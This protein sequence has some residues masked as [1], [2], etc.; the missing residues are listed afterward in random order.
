[1]RTRRALPPAEPRQHCI[2][3]HI[4]FSRP[5]SRVFGESV[6]AVRRRLGRRLAQ[7][8]PAEADVVIAVPDSSNSIALG[9]SEASGMPLRAGAHPQPLRRPHVH[10][11]AAGRARFRR[12]REVQSR[13][14]DARRQARRGGG[15]LDRARHDQPQAGPP[16]S[17]RGRERGALPRRLAAGHAPVLL[18]DRHAQPARVDR[19]AQDRSRRSASTS[20]WTRWATSR[21]RACWPARRRPRNFCRACF[22]GEYPVAVD[23]DAGKLVLEN[24]RRSPTGAGR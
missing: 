1:M 6:D 7:E 22:T 4:Y 13:A 18:R 2:F 5:D 10:R 9:F 16:A 23:P 24:L 15:R 14:R 20:A 8:H 11:A 19:R 3:E 12:A 17:P 21:W